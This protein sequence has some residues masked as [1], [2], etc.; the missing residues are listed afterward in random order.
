MLLRY[1]KL[2]NFYFSCGRVDRVEKNYFSWLQ[3]AVA[4]IS[5][6]YL[7]PQPPPR[8]NRTSTTAAHEVPPTRPEGNGALVA[9][10]SQGTAA[11]M[12]SPSGLDPAHPSGFGR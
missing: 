5:L 2:P 8:T 1:E 4:S 3:L 7:G 6:R 12:A 10:V 11:P 9:M